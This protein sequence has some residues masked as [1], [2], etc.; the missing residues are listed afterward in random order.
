MAQPLFQ[1]VSRMLHRALGSALG[2]TLLFST[3]VHLSL[4]ALSFRP[5]APPSLKL[6]VPEL[7]LVLV[8]AQTA[9]APLKAAVLAQVHLNGG[10]RADAGQAATL[11]P[12]STWSRSG[13]ALEETRAQLSQLEAQQTLL[14]AKV[15]RQLHELEAR[16]RQPSKE[17]T[18]AQS[19]E[20]QRQ[21]MVRL[22]AQIERRI[23]MESTR[24]KRLFAQISAQQSAAA[25]Y[26]DHM[27]Q[28]LEDQG[29]RQFP[30]QA[31]QRLYGELIVE[32][33]V[34]SSGQVLQVNVLQ[35]SG[36]PALD[37]QASRLA[38]QQRFGPFDSRLRQQAD[39]LV[40]VSTFRFLRD[41]RMV[42]QMGGQL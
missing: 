20:E 5:S 18:G 29:T 24:P 38:R 28:V 26:F 42:T 8:N 37:D 9:D 7:E 23:E 16:D 13:D 2:W 3:A 25:L 36:Q 17:D 1:P 22:I 40:V 6:P 33:T 15:K 19:Q 32:L 39:Q 21:A 14:L 31:G 41:N 27:R 11:L 4:I 30:S 34:H 10:G 35:T 12:P